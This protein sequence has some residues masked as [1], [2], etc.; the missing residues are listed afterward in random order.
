MRTSRQRAGSRGPERNAEEGPPEHETPSWLVR[1]GVIVTIVASVAGLLTTGVATLY[2]SL[3]ADDQLDQSQQVAEEKRSEQAARVSY[4]VDRPPG[5]KSRVHLMNRSP[6]PI[7]NVTMTFTVNLPE[8]PPTSLSAWASFAVLLPSVPPC[9]DM[10]FSSDD[11]RYTDREGTR[12]YAFGT[13]F[14]EVPRSQGWR[15]PGGGGPVINLFAARFID[16]NGVSWVR[17]RG[18]LTRGARQLEPQPGQLGVVQSVPP[19]ALK[20]CGGD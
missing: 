7:S 12:R 17:E 10:V 19:Q 20:S 2:S 4:W 9:S 1:V 13:P 5:G 8:H 11:L 15:A 6:D 3:V 16:R 18:L 14:D